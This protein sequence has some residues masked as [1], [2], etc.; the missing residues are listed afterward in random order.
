MQS[1]CCINRL[2]NSKFSAYSLLA[3]RTKRHFIFSSTPKTNCIEFVQLLFKMDSTKTKLILF[4][5]QICGFC[6]L[7]SLEKFSKKK[8]TEL[9][10]IWSYFHLIIISIVVVLAI[11]YSNQVFVTREM[12]SAFTDVMQFAL[13]VLSQ[14]IIIIESLRTKYIKCRFWIRI[15]HMDKFLLNTTLQMKQISIN[16]FII[17][18]TIILVT[19][20]T[21]EILSAIRV[22]SDEVWSNN[23]LIS[24]YTSI[25][26]RSQVLFCVFFIDTLKNRT[27]MIA[28]RLKEIQNSGKNRL[29]ILRCCKKSYGMLWLSVE[30]INRAF[31]LRNWNGFFFKQMKIILKNSFQVGHFLQP[32]FHT[33]SVSVL[34]YI[35]RLQF[36]IFDQVHSHLKHSS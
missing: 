18:F 28:I 33:L 9:L 34:V 23:I 20:T 16:K 25:V 12:I 21:I 6:H 31:G 22:N 17:K 5:F 13:P 11:Y 10:I 32:S 24:L 35:G 30:D 3:F 29:I 4:Y 14:Y 27:N 1:N 19:T 26:C 7:T 2:P 15:Q 8:S 36:D